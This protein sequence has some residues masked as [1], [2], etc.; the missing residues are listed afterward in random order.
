MYDVDPIIVSVYGDFLVAINQPKIDEENF[1]IR[2]FK[3]EGSKSNSAFRLSV[4]TSPAVSGLEESIVASVPSCFYERSRQY[5]S[6]IRQTE[7][8]SI[9]KGNRFLYK[10]YFNSFSNIAMIANREIWRSKS[11]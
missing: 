4:N 8:D 10:N 5:H 1:N 3:L 9:K 7:T 11:L 2:H 6:I